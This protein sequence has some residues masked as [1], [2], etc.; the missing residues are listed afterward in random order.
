[1][2]KEVKHN[3]E[4]LDLYSQAIFKSTIESH[5]KKLDYNKQVER[6]KRLIKDYVEG[7]D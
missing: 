1:M 4:K 3:E 5:S 2:N 7:L 6:I